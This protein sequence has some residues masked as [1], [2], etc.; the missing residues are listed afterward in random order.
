MF[1][2]ATVVL[3]ILRGIWCILGLTEAPFDVI[4]M[5]VCNLIMFVLSILCIF[6]GVRKI[7]LY[8][9]NVGMVTLCTLIVMRFFDSG[10]PLSARGVIFLILG[11]G[12][13]LF[14]LYFVKKKKKI[15]EET[16]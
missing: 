9:A 14:N 10:L 3:L 6:V 5:V 11:A 13:L 12:F 2:I 1:S 7:D 15:K 16:I 8:N 4:F